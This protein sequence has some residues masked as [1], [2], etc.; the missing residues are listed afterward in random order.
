MRPRWTALLPPEHGSWAFLLL[1]ILVGLARRPS[2]AGALLAISA[3]CAFLL[4]VPMERRR[5]VRFHPDAEA[6]IRLLRPMGELSALFVVF[7]GWGH[8]IIAAALS[9]ALGAS[10]LGA[11]PPKV[12][13]SVAWELGGA[14]LL[15]L[16]APALLRLGGS[17][18]REA[19]WVW[20]FL[21]FFTLPPVLYL[22]QRLDRTCD[23]A[24]VRISLAAH[25]AALLL[26]SAAFGFRAAPLVF[27]IWAGLLAARALWGAARPAHPG[28]GARLG[29]AEA[30][31]G[32]VHAV[33]LSS[34]RSL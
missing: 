24:R 18:L 26:V 3:L 32:L 19:A 21:A 15:T 33:L 2:L 12:R 29:A 7:L 22:R 11:K 16:L 6:W 25:G 14:A 13:R 20:A 5:G 27:L 31:L 30:S 8:W 9:L 1:P 10:L 28:S 23:P 17:S 4:R 34:W